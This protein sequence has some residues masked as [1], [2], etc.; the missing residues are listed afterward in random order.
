MAAA[1]DARATDCASPHSAV[2]SPAPS[3]RFRR[4]ECEGRPLAFLTLPSPLRV[5]F[6]IF[7]SIASML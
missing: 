5:S 7:R 2:A 1:V 6:E 3:L 4:K